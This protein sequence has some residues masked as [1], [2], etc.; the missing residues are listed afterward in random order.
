MRLPF[1]L[2][3]A[4]ALLGCATHPQKPAAAKAFDPI[5]PA[6]PE[7]LETAKQRIHLLRADMTDEQVFAT[8]GLGDC[9]GRCF[10][11][12]GGPL[13][14][15]WVSYHLRSPRSGLHIVHEIKLTVPRKTTLRCVT[16]DEVS[17]RRDEK[18]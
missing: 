12:G 1:P 15:A 8:L 6:T 5:N 18:N 14:H 3:L 17:W 10:A 11:N 9:Y 7:Q 13:S 4:C 2:L 16:L